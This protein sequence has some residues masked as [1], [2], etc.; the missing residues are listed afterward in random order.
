VAAASAAFAA[1][2]A[3][4]GAGGL[5]DEDALLTEADR[6]AP[7][8][9]DGEACGPG[10]RKACKDCTCGLKEEL[11]AGGGAAEAPKKDFKSACGNCSLGDAF[12]C[13]G[14]PYLGQPAF[15]E[16]EKVTLE[17]TDDI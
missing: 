6:E 5:V 9:P 14:C 3:G 8:R 13:A 15:S 16:G 10:R 2:A 12:R 7:A 1:A 11:E 4:V 17:L